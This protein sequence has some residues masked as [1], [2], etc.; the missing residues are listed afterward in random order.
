MP[1]CTKLHILE[2]RMNRIP[3]MT[4]LLSS[5]ICL[6]RTYLVNLLLIGIVGKAGTQLEHLYGCGSY[7]K[8]ISVTPATGTPVSLQ[9]CNTPVSGA[10]T[11]PVAM[12]RL[13][14]DGHVRK[15]EAVVPDILFP[16][17]DCYTINFSI[18]WQQW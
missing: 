17:R 12:R 2:F 14:G 5:A 16:V 4:S 18:S 8:V 6:A 9:A 11:I 7:A 3:L 10:L 15:I 1:A 13:Q